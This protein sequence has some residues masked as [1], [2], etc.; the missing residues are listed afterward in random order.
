LA[1]NKSYNQL[2][3][4]KY[5]RIKKKLPPLLVKSINKAE[6]EI[7]K[8]PSIGTQKHGDLKGLYVH[9]FKPFDQKLL[10]AYEVNNKKREVIFIAIGG[11]ENFYRDLKQYL[12]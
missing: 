12:K 5:N 2:A 6:N 9:K 10:L 7:A 11:H 8:N 1:K 3:Y 4:P